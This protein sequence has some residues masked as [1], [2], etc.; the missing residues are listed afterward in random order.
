MDA[1]LE[2]FRWRAFKVNNPDS[3]LSFQDWCRQ[4][5]IQENWERRNFGVTWDEY[6]KEHE[7]E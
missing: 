5:A 1:L 4:R 6:L 3:T 2:L 7:D